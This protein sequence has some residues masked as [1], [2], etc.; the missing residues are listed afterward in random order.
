[1]GPIGGSQFLHAMLEALFD[2]GVPR[3]GE[4]FSYGRAHNRLSV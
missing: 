2:K 4:A 3:L 1:M